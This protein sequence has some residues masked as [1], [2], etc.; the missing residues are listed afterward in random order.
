MFNVPGLRF[1]VSGFLLKVSL[2]SV[3]GC[4]RGT[5]LHFYVC[6]EYYSTPS[7]LCWHSGWIHRIAC[8]AIEVESLRDSS[9]VEM[10]KLARG[11]LQGS[12]GERGRI[13]SSKFRIS[14]SMD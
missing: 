10:K 3:F 4:K 13:Q 12:E 5:F 7:G 2:L 11:S 8:G 9:V 1:K 6:K 14:D